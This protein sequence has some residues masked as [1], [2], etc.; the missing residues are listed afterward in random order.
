VR[1]TDFNLLLLEDN[2]ARLSAILGA[3]REAHLDSRLRVLRDRED[4]LRHLSQLLH[5]PESSRALAFPSLFLLDLEGDAALSV[6]E[7]LSRQPRLRRM[8]KV[9]LF[10]S[11]DGVVTNRAYALGVNSC[12]VRPESADGLLDLFVS[13]GRYWA[14]LNHPPEL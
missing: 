11:G 8:V 5:G 4:A 12:L 1:L 6:L 14:D 2:P 9:G 10:S 13:I 7:W 3:V